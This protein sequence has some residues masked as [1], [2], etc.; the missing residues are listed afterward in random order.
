MTQILENIDQCDITLWHIIQIKTIMPVLNVSTY[1]ITSNTAYSIGFPAMIVIMS[2]LT[3]K[4]AVI[5]YIET[6]LFLHD[7][8]LLWLIGIW[9]QL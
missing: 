4:T 6:H 8:Y 3:F 2:V 1:I 7:L 5:L 9:I